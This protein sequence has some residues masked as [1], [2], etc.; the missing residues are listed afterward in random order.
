M[1]GDVTDKVVGDRE[2]RVRGHR[3]TGKRPVKLTRRTA[4]SASPRFAIMTHESRDYSTQ[5]RYEYS[6]LLSEL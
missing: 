5:L 3:Y 4:L 6:T 1:V 2:L